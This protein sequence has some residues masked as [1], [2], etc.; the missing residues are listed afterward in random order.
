[1]QGYFF[2]GGGLFSMIGG[3]MKNGTLKRKLINFFFTIL[4]KNSF[5]FLLRIKLGWDVL[6]PVPLLRS[7]ANSGE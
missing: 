1:M 2:Q 7:A 4:P 3:K 5:I 6:K